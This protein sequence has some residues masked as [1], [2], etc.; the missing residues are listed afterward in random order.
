MQMLIKNI[1]SIPRLRI[2]IAAFV[3]GIALSGCSLIGVPWPVSVMTTVGDVVSVNQTGKSLSEN[4]ASEAL[5]R[6]CQ[7]SRILMGWP[8]CLTSDELAERLLKMNC[9]T[10]AWNIINIPYCKE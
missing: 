8:P 9:D 7:W 5:S 4:A 10:Y 1:I 2:C 6:D 3:A